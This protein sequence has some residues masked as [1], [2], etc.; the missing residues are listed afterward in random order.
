METGYKLYLALY[1]VAVI[2]TCIILRKDLTK[3][4]LDFSSKNSAWFFFFFAKAE[5]EISSLVN[6]IESCPH[7]INSYDA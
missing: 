4:A 7:V 2:G 6:E 1:T 3:A 5:S